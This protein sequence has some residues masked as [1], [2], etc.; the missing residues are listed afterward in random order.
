MHADRWS[1]PKP[2]GERIC[3]LIGKQT[4]EASPDGQACASRRHS[5]MTRTTVDRL[6]NEGKMVYI[7]G[8]KQ[9]RKG[10]EE[11]VWIP[12]ATFVIARRWRKKMSVDE[13][14]AMA[15]MQLVS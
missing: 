11:P 14:G 10:V 7:K 5:H 13:N 15:T 6:V 8:V 3:V 2:K 12:V 9:N 4:W 1:V